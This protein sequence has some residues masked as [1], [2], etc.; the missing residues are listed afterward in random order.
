MFL[1]LPDEDC[2]LHI[3]KTFKAVPPTA[4]TP[5][6]VFEISDR[7]PQKELET[8]FRNVEV[9]ARIS[10]EVEVGEFK[11]NPNYWLSLDI[12]VVNLV[13]AVSNKEDLPSF[14]IDGNGVKAFNQWVNK[15]SAKLKSKGKTDLDRKLWRYR[16]KRIKGIFHSVSN[17][18]ISVCLRHNIGKIILPK[19]LEK[20][21]QRESQKSAK[22]NQEFR[23]LP[24]G[25]LLEMIRYKAELFG[26]E[27]LEEPETFTSKVSSI[28]GNI[29]VISGKK[30]EELTEED[31]KKLKFEGKREKRGLF[32]DL[33]L[34]KVFNADLNGALNLA[35]KRLGKKVREGF[36]K[37]KNWIDKL[38]RAIKVS[39]ES[40]FVGIGG[41]SS[42]PL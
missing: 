2:E 19:G 26:I 16:A 4:D 14:I 25:K 21:Y 20:E 6:L 15:L 29:E 13:S 33:R 17:K 5:I 41:S 10:Y 9:I 40:P 22:F 27:V 30:K 34:N 32:R 23:F 18:I 37:L 12:G 38:S 28:S 1:A 35:I 8:W 39:P 31:Y 42:Y 24:L 11:P 36:L 3:Q 7:N